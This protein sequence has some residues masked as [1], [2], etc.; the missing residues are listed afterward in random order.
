M[1]AIGNRLVGKRAIQISMQED[2]IME[3]IFHSIQMS[4]DAHK[5]LETG[6]VIKFGDCDWCVLDIQGEWAMVFL[7]AP[8]ETM[9]FHDGVINKDGITWENCT[10]RH[11]L[12][13][14]FYDS[15]GERDKA[16]IGSV[17]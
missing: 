11:Y 2:T 8:G 5:A 13:N 7:D 1:E 14:E 17:M 3:T 6:D 4:S 16:W 10:L 12:N 9:P 15:L